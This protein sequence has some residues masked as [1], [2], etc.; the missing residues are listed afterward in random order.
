MTEDLNPWVTHNLFFQM[1]VIL[2]MLTKF[3]FYNLN[4]FNYA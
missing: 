2:V 1:I 3:D 4:T